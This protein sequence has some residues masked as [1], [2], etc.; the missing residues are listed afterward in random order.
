MEIRCKRWLVKPYKCGGDRC[1]QV[2]RVSENGRVA[3]V[4]ECY[5]VRL[6]D[7]LSWCAEYEMRNDLDQ[8]V[9]LSGCADAVRSVYAGFE[10][11]V[12]DSLAAR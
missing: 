11:A 3:S 12:D 9:E 8:S 2:S 10:R 1:W 6:A 4:A 5:H 7:A